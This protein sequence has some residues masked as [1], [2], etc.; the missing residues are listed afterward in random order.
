MRRQR[1]NRDGEAEKAPIV[2]QYLKN[3]NKCSTFQHNQTNLSPSLSCC[4]PL[5]LSLSYFNYFRKETNSEE[6]YRSCENE[7]PHRDAPPQ[8]L[9]P[10]DGSQRVRPTLEMINTFPFFATPLLTHL[11]PSFSFV[12]M[13]CH[14]SLSFA[15]FLSSTFK[16]YPVSYFCN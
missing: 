11:F 10:C 14:V 9:C 16:T 6:K 13:L 15:V 3:L 5:F 7:S 12:L 4:R 1:R 8:K 2:R